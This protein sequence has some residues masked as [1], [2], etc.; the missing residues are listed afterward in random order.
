MTNDAKGNNDISNF[1]VPDDNDNDVSESILQTLLDNK[2]MINECETNTMLHCIKTMLTNAN[3][4]LEPPEVTFY[5]S[6]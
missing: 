4:S 1:I 3:E 2:D 5:T 6:A